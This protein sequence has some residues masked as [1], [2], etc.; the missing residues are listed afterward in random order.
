MAYA[1]VDFSLMT[2]IL[3]LDHDCLL[4]VNEED[5]ISVKH[6]FPYLILWHKC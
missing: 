5:I 1:S 6:I 3:V 2:D 4:G